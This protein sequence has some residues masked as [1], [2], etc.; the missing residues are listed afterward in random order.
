M[1]NVFDA[2]GS[3][4]KVTHGFTAVGPLEHAWGSHDGHSQ[5]G[6]LTRLP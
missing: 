1:Q 6:I 4:R 3:K 2:V 5:N